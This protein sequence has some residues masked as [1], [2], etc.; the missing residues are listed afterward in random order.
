MQE[1]YFKKSYNMANSD[2]LYVNNNYSI[3]IRLIL[4]Y[5]CHTQVLEDRVLRA[6]SLSS[7]LKY[8]VQTPEGIFFAIASQLAILR[9][10]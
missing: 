9:L 7:D 4:S 2:L 3:E 5:P 6:Q 1:S 10:Y 8:T